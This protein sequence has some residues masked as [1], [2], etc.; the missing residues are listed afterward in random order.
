MRLY[1]S[2]SDTKAREVDG[3]NVVDYFIGS[4]GVVRL[5]FL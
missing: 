5:A 2:V 4:N 1:G 3:I